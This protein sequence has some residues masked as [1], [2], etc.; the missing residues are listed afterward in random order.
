MNLDVL[1]VNL[2]DPVRFFPL[3]LKIVTAFFNNRSGGIDIFSSYQQS[4]V[5][6]CVTVFKDLIENL[7]L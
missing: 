4:S 6:K 7:P 2:G 5:D 1:I 3:L